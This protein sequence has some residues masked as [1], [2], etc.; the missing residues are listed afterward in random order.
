VSGGVEVDPEILLYVVRPDGPLHLGGCPRL[1]TGARANFMSWATPASHAQR[2]KNPLCKWCEAELSGKR[3]TYYE[4]LDAALKALGLVTYEDRLQVHTV[5]E[6]I[7]FDY[8][9]IPAGGSYVALQR[10]RNIVREI[11]KGYLDGHDIERVEFPWFRTRDRGGKRTENRRGESC[12]RC[13]LERSL[14]GGCDNCD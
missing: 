10:D 14:T 12:P 9:W 2:A 1:D 5:L 8:V 6:G 4:T 11:H 3:R 7:E 13:G